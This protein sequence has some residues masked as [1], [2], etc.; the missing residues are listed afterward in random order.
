MQT[1]KVS[2]TQMYV[3]VHWRCLEKPEWCRFASVLTRQDFHIRATTHSE[4]SI[5]WLSEI[6]ILQKVLGREIWEKGMCSKKTD[7]AMT[8][9]SPSTMLSLAEQSKS[10]PQS[11]GALWSS[12]P[13]SF[14][15]RLRQTYELAWQ[16]SRYWSKLAREWHVRWPLALLDRPT[17]AHLVNNCGHGNLNEFGRLHVMREPFL[18]IDEVNRE[19]WFCLEGR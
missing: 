1:P 19:E 14:L 12:K 13:G 17:M 18:A 8:S 3:S 9:L 7:L 5:I 10:G 15:L 16:H 4:S 2:S 11:L 6:C